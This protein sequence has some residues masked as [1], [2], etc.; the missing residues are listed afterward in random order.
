MVDLKKYFDKTI[1]INLDERQD[2]YDNFKKEISK[3]N[4]NNIERFSAIDGKKI[5]NSNNFNLL[6]GEIGIIH[7]HLEIIKLAIKEKLKNILI[8]EDDVYFTDELFKLDEYMSLV[9]KDW[10]FIYFG[11]NHLY[12]QPPELVNN[13]IIKLNYTVALQCIAI[14]NTMFEIIESILS[15]FKKQVDTHYAELHNRF[16]S[17]CFYPSI[18]KQTPGFSDIQNKNV[19]YDNFF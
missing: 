4:I 8:L 12:G 6:P 17:Y 10:D 14:N 11:G 15:N 5:N 9:P 18:A 19:N 7:S 13:K 3:F 1:V 2:R 16:N